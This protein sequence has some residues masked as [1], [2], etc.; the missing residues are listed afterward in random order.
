MKNFYFRTNL[1][2]K[3]GI[4]NYMRVSRLAAIL[5]KKG[6]VCTIFID[7]HLKNF[8]FVKNQK[9]KFLYNN[10]NYISEENDA[11]TFISQTH[12]P[13]VV[14]LDDYRFQRTWQKKVRFYHKKLV[15]IDD[16]LNRSHACDVLV[17]SKPN[18]LNKKFEDSFKKKNKNI[19]LLLGPKYCII[20]KKISKSKKPKKKFIIT[21]YN[22]GSGD[23]L[24][25]YNILKKLNNS[26]SVDLG[27]FHYNVVIGS[28]SKN[29]NKIFSLKKKF[30]NIEIINSKNNIYEK[31]NNTNLFIGSAGISIFETALYKIPTILFKV[32]K[33]Q[34]VDL[35]SLEKIGHFLLLDES[36]LYNCE[37]IS[38]LIISLY[39]KYSNFKKIFE[40]IDFNIDDKGSNRVVS[41][42]LTRTKKIYTIN[43]E[44]K[45]KQ[46]KKK[47]IYSISKVDGKYINKYLLSR[48]LKINRTN[49]LNKKKIDN[50]SHYLWWFNNKRES[51]VFKK[52]ED[53][54]IFFYHETIIIKNFSFI[55]PGWCLIN[56]KVSFLD[57]LRA[58]EIQKKIIDKQNYSI[59]NLGIIKKSNTSMVKFA[60]NLNWEI[61][62]THEKIYK[63]LCK[64]LNLKKEFVLFKR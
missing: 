49:S 22:G 5:E 40:S 35:N 43:K 20:D 50:L 10:Q 31:I 61:I 23:L 13:G 26:K 24:S 6:H 51:Y 2:K 46:W 60:K 52:N 58:L 44:E 1:G 33:N 47:Q 64:S 11:N 27:I 39:K 29:K 25:I 19:K 18:F 62:H 15:V 36:D 57:I 48:N 4:G 14:I 9:I 8:N 54:I 12:S 56:S 30:R 28:F 38:E 21:F 34:E 16:F 55:K 63:I 17:N 59:P 42:I 45:N 41:E 7:K 3:I 37:K 53:E 32:S